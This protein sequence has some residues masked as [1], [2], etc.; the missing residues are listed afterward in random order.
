MPEGA[1]PQ[2]VGRIVVVDEDVRL[3][4]LDLGGDGRSTTGR[5]DVDRRVEG[6]P[7]VVEHRVVLALAHLETP[8]GRVVQALLAGA[9]RGGNRV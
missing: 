2:L 1:L 3:G 8:I 6:R 5:R 7:G 9:C 4:L